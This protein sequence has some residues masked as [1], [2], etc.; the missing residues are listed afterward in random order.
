MAADGTQL[1]RRES[2][3]DGSSNSSRGLADNLCG[4]PKSAAPIPFFDLDAAMTAAFAELDAA[5]GPGSG[6]WRPLSEDARGFGPA[7]FEEDR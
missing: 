4:A 2:L 6:K 5:L 3:S 7:R 1:A